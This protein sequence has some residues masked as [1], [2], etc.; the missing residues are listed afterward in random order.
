MSGGLPERL[1]APESTREGVVDAVC[2]RRLS[3]AAAWGSVG[4]GSVS[5]GHAYTSV[6]DRLP[7]PVWGVRGGQRFYRTQCIYKSVLESQL[8]HKTVN[9]SNSQQ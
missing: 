9:F 1:A 3:T 2:L 8:H 6:K 7:P 5:V 4:N